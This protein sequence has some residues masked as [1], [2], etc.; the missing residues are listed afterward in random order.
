[1]AKIRLLLVDDHP[2]F[3]QGLRRLMEM[4]EDMEVA[5]EASDGPEAEE[6]AELVKPDVILMDIALPGQ[7]G[8]QTTTH[9]L[10]HNP[11]AKVLMLTMHS[12]QEKVL[13]ALTQG[14]KGYV[15]KTAE[16]EELVRAIRAVHQGE[17]FLSPSAAR[18]LVSD[19]RRLKERGAAPQRLALSPGETEI[20]TLLARGMSNREIAQQLYL[21]EK[22]VRN[23]LSIVFR[24]LGVKNRSQAILHFLGQQPSPGL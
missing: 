3:R 21:S 17:E 15:L 24:K 10:Q 5:A 7:D 1:M 2:L 6:K 4:E 19:W 11:Q 16:M 23:R 13:A 12:D 14:A 18:A 8:T 9:I 22:T 20:L